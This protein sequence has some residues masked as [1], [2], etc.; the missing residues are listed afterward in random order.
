VEFKD[1]AGHLFERSNAMQA[2]WGYYITIA[3]ALIGFFGTA[4]RSTTLAAILTGAFIGVAIVNL[5]GMRDVAGQRVALRRLLDKASKATAASV[6]RAPLPST[7]VIDTYLSS[8]HPPLVFGVVAT[9][10][11][12]DVVV[13]AAIWGLTLSGTKC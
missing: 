11:V 9:H 2:F 1:V 10:V 6:F 12:C 3:L 7:E 5:G 13:I 8:V 4:H